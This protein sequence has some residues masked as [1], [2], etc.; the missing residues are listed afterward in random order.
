MRAP[1]AGVTQKKS[2]PE[3]AFL[4]S[5]KISL[6]FLAAQSLQFAQGTQLG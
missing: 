1:G 3:V 4:A 5:L 6:L 2:D